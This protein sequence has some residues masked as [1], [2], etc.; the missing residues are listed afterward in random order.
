M[1]RTILI[2][3]LAALLCCCDR[4]DDVYTANADGG[5]A[6]SDVIHFSSISHLELDA[7]SSS[8]STVTVN[9]SPG[10]APNNRDIIFRTSL[11]R[12][13]NRDT[14]FVVRANALGIAHV[15]LL[16]DSSGMASVSAQVGSY[17]IDTTMV[18]KPA[19][20]DDMLSSLDQYVVNNNTDVTVTT[21]LY[22]NPGRGKV[23]DPVKVYYELV[24][25]NTVVSELVYPAFS[26]SDDGVAKA[27]LR[28]PYNIT[29]QFRLQVKAVSASGD[30]LRRNMILQVQ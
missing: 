5:V 2:L 18:F 9:I 14:T 22:R 6:I 28:N 23:S 27:V 26:F 16:S 15:M 25:L 17:R 8:R 4:D 30:T 3:T 20:P 24:P 19:L 21:R 10:A 13:N 29:G 12:F 7:D 1:K 11:G